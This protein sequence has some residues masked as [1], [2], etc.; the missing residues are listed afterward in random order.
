LTE[1][2]AKAAWMEAAGKA[3]AESSAKGAKD[4]AKETE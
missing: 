2:E 1:E 4:S 3:K